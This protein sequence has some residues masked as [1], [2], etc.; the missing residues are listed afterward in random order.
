M[1]SQKPKNTGSSQSIV[2]ISNLKYQANEQDLLD[3]FKS[4]EFDPLRARLLY[5]NEGNSK[6]TGFVELKNSDE[7][8]AAV[9][10]LQG[11]CCQGRPVKVNLANK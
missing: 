2:Y 5:D 7:A 1:I 9:D 10:K 3:F 4:F 11:E 6:G 8:T